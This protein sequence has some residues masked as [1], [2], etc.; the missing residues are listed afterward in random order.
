MSDFEI[1]ELRR[2]VEDLERRIGALD[3]GGQ[4]A[5]PPQMDPEVAAHIQSGNLIGA[6]KRYREMTGV[7]LAEAKTAIEALDS[8]VRFD[9]GFRRT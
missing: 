9:N 6:I 4:P 5:P 7:G 2:R 1:A 8:S 3:A